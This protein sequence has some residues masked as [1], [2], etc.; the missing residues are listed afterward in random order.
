MQ[1]DHSAAKEFDEL[2]R[3]N[4]L[5]ISYDGEEPSDDDPEGGFIDKMLAFKSKGRSSMINRDSKQAKQKR[6][7]NYDSSEKNLT[8]EGGFEDAG[9]ESDEIETYLKTEITKRNPQTLPDFTD[10]FK[11]FLKETQKDHEQLDE[12]SDFDE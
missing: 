1:F 6:M 9:I 2:R 12:D 5:G 11:K 7:D 4:L 8:D 3:K 10:C